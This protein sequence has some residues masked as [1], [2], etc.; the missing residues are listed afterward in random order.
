MTNRNNT[1]NLRVAIY[2]CISSH[3]EK[4]EQE[5]YDAIIKANSNWSL[6]KTYI[7]EELNDNDTSKIT[8]LIKDAKDD[9]FDLI[10]SKDIYKFTR[11]TIDVFEYILTLKKL[12][13]EVFFITDCIWT[14]ESDSE[15]RLGILSLILHEEHKKL[16]KRLY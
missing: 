16:Q 11:N 6:V 9:A 10:I 2:E 7:S 14:F 13:K 5:Y 12:G 3:N 8:E 1:E 15:L 4:Y